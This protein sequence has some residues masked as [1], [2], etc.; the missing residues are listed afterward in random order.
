MNGNRVI[1]VSNY[2]RK[3]PGVSDNYMKSI[4]GI[5]QIGLLILSIVLFIKFIKNIIQKKKAGFILFWSVLLFM[6][7][8]IIGFWLASLEPISIMVL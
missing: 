2:A 3:S 5:I 8:I 4:M 7:H 1:D 6:I